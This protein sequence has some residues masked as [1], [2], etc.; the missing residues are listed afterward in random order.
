[1]NL[2]RAVFS[3]IFIRN[4]WV[5]LL[6]FILAVAL[7]FIA[8]EETVREVDIEIPLRVRNLASDRVMLSEPPSEVRV[9]VRGHL[10]RLT[11]VLA[12]KTPFEIDLSPYANN[13]S[14]EFSPAALAKHLG[15][16]LE[17]LSVSPSGFT[18]QFDEMKE[19]RVPVA[20]NVYKTPGPFWSVVREK[21]RV[22]P[23]S[24]TVKG[25]S[26][27]LKRVRQIHTE[28]LDLSDVTQSFSGKL[29]LE[30]REGLVVSPRSVRVE[31]PVVERQGSKSIPKAKMVVK[32]C[33]AGF[34]CSV[35]P[36]FFHV[37]IAGPER[38]VSQ[39]TPENVS[40]YVYL[41]ADKLPV[42]AELLQKHFDVV[43][44]TMEKLQG[45]VL[46]L[47]GP[48]FFSITITRAGEDAGGG[49]DA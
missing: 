1:M 11:E 9:L 6:S 29:A 3:A 40:Q 26:T 36:P 17:V 37:R 41:D 22:E 12:R 30:E 14:V 2:L 27:R 8:R 33:P 24:V 39:L 45:A 38:I 35:S 13:S 20:V 5:K 49:P 19:K 21:M 34:T 23:S 4:G 44:P 43:E 42:E 31:V 16:D 32:N 25:P 28:P 15:E 47:P 48:K 18:L 46:E 7:F 10:L